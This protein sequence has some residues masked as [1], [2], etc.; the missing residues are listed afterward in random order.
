M[1]LLKGLFIYN[2][3]KHN[4]TFIKYIDELIIEAKIFVPRKID[5]RKEKSIQIINKKIQKYIDDGCIGDLDLTELPIV[6]LPNN[7]VKVGRSMSL[8]DCKSLVSLPDNLHV[9]GDLSLSY[10]KSLKS[11]PSNL[12]VGG[13]IN[14][15]HCKSLVSLP[16]DFTKVGDDL[17]LSDCVSLKSLPNNLHV[18]GA[19]NLY[20]CESLESLPNNLY[21]GEYLQIKNTPISK[22][23]NTQDRIR[24]YLKS[25]NAI[26]RGEILV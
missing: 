18:G 17:Y 13:S 24:N 1:P 4:E 8:Y 14:L 25:I 12:Y 16:D 15:G 19:L 5:S 23:Y 20:E 7:L 2:N 21:V 26:I 3:M 10:C 6:N 22:K 11:L 9:V